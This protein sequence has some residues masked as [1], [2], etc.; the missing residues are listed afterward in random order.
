MELPEDV[1]TK[2]RAGLPAWLAKR[3]PMD[4]KLLVVDGQATKNEIDI[5]L[6]LTIGRERGVGLIISHPLV[7]RKHCVISR[8][9]DALWVKDFDSAN[10]T[11][12]NG[13][14]INEGQLRPG[15]KL[16]VG[17]LTF[18]A[19]Y[20][21]NGLMSSRQL[22][23]K[24][25]DDVRKQRPSVA[26][27]VDDDEKTPLTIDPHADE[28]LRVQSGED[29]ADPTSGN[30][31][32]TRSPGDENAEG[33]HEPD[34]AEAGDE[35]EM[36]LFFTWAAQSAASTRRKARKAQEEAER[37]AA[38]KAAQHG[39]EASEL[40][41]A[42]MKQRETHPEGDDAAAMKTLLAGALA[43]AAKRASE[44][45]SVRSDPTPVP[46][47]AEDDDPPFSDSGTSTPEEVCGSVLGWIDRIQR[48]IVERHRETAMMVEIINR[49]QQEQLELTRQQ[50][51]RLYLLTTLLKNTMTRQFPTMPTAPPD[52]LGEAAAEDAETRQEGIERMHDWLMERTARLQDADSRAWDRI[53]SHL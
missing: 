29:G 45:V 36:D 3:R 34:L 47:A 46:A 28:A 52:A 15:D 44:V 22:A 9:D 14:K 10:G 32:V 38:E 7:S 30:P 35:E 25:A 27:E 37:L 6:P 50:I 40:L 23:K 19:V 16:T 4:P 18:V 1:S 11:M 12:I 2:R 8:R 39:H 20:R 26:A 33:F 24:F 42:D 5:R 51:S 17:P 13:R 49:L 41:E 48:Q 21:Q 43:E 53:R 31:S